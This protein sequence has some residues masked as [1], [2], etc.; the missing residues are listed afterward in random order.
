MLRQ[1][2]S[3]RKD[4]ETFGKTKSKEKIELKFGIW[5]KQVKAE[6]PAENSNIW[7]CHQIMSRHIQNVFLLFWKFLRYLVRV[8]S[9]CFTSIN[10]SSLSR[11]KYGGVYSRSSPS[12]ITKA[13]HVGGNKVN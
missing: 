4:T 7:W 2:C 12:A 1:K 11:K 9:M 13:K 3:Y 5:P 8:Q 6:F 10:W